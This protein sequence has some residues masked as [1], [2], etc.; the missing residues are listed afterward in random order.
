MQIIYKSSL[1]MF[2]HESL[3]II[4]INYCVSVFFFFINHQVFLENLKRL[5]NKYFKINI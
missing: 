1:T 5:Y 2:T 4:K 3:E